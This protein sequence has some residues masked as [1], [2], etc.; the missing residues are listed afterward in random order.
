MQPKPNNRLKARSRADLAAMHD[1]AAHRDG[2]YFSAP[3]KLAGFKDT[4]SALDF[5][6]KHPDWTVR[7]EPPE[8][9]ET[10]R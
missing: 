2:T 6:A 7:I 5:R 9:K 3:E 4:D 1:W 8:D 10:G